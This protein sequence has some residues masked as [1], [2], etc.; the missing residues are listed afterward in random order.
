[1]AANLNFSSQR[2]LRPATLASLTPFLAL[3]PPVI[4]SLVMSRSFLPEL[5]WSESIPGMGTAMSFLTDRTLS[6]SGSGDVTKGADVVVT[7]GVVV[8]FAARVP[9]WLPACSSNFLMLISGLG[10]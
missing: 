7:T 9:F 3:T 10:V 6:S 5:R 8:T 1:M 4:S 2:A